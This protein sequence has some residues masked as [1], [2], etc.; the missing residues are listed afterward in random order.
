[1]KLGNRSEFDEH[2]E[3]ADL[4]QEPTIQHQDALEDM[5]KITSNT[6]GIND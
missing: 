6:D 5:Q 4:P 2:S 1:M 3:L